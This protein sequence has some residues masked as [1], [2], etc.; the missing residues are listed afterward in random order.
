LFNLPEHGAGFD[1]GENNDGTSAPLD[2][3]TDTGS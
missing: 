3:I 1:D 2:F